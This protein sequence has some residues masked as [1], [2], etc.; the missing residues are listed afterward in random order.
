[1]NQSLYNDCFSVFALDTGLA[2]SQSVVVSAWGGQPYTTSETINTS[3]FIQSNGL[4]LGSWA[5]SL[6][7]L[8]FSETQ[9]LVLPSF[10]FRA[11]ITKESRILD[12]AS[13]PERSTIL[14]DDVECTLITIGFSGN[15]SDYTANTAN[16]FSILF[17]LEVG[18]DVI[19]QNN[20]T[21]HI[22]LGRIHMN[23]TLNLPKAIQQ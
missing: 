20:P 4:I 22:T 8:G 10:E 18:Q 17:F 11:Q 5:N 3:S 6:I 1:M 16:Q 7:D 13:R 14:K 15:F 19:I 9:R 12:L 23:G 21:K 2:N